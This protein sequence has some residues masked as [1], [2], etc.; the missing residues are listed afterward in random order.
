MIV[1]AAAIAAA[2]AGMPALAEVARVLEVK[3]AGVVERA[4]RPARILGAGEVLEQD[5]VVRIAPASHAILDFGERGRLT[6]RPSTVLRL[7]SPV[8]AVAKLEQG[9]VR[10]APGSSSNATLLTPVG[11][12]SGSGAAF[13]ARLCASDCG[14]DTTGRPAGWPA[15]GP[16]LRAERVSGEVRAIGA[17]RVH[18]PLHVGG[19]VQ[20]GDEVMT[21][22]NGR[23][24][25]QVRDGGFVVLQPRTRFV[26][27]RF[28]Y[29]LRR[30]AAAVAEF[31]LLSGRIQAR[32]GAIGKARPVGYRITTALGELRTRGTVL[33]AACTDLCAAGAP[34]ASMDR[35]Q[36]PLGTNGDVVLPNGVVLETRRDANGV[37]R[38]FEKLPSRGEP[39][40]VAADGTPLYANGLP[41]TDGSIEWRFEVQ[42]S[43]QAVFTD[44]RKAS[45]AGRIANIV[46]GESVPVGAVVV[47]DGMLTFLDA[48]PY[49]ANETE[50]IVGSS[51]GPAGEQ[52]RIEQRTTRTVD[53]DG[54]VRETPASGITGNLQLADGARLVSGDGPQIGNIVDSFLEARDRLLAPGPTPPAVVPVEPAEAPA[55]KPGEI[56]LPNGVVLETRL[57]PDGNVRYFEKLPPRGEPIAWLPDGTP[58]FANGLGASDGNI[59]WRFRVEPGGR[60]VFENLTGD[61]GAGSPVPVASVLARDGSLTFLAAPPFRENETAYIEQVGGRDVD[62]RGTRTI[63]LDGAISDEPGAPPLGSDIRLADG[64]RIVSDGGKI[65]GLMDGFVGARAAELRT[66]KPERPA[67]PPSPPP[68]A[69]QPPLGSSGDVV[70]PGGVV[71]EARRG[72]DGTLRFFEKQPSRGEPIG[73]LPDGSPL[74]ADGL[75]PTDG[76]LEWKFFVYENGQAAFINIAE[77]DSSKANTSGSDV[78]E[79]L[80]G[81][82][83]VTDGALT[84]LEVPPYRQAETGDHHTVRHT[85]VPSQVDG[86][87]TRSINAN[88]VVIDDPA[89]VPLPADTPLAGGGRLV[90]GGGAALQDV[91]SAYLAARDGFLP[92]GASPT[93]P[94]ASLPGSSGGLTVSTQQGSVDVISPGG[95]TSV[96]AGQTVALT[97]DSPANPAGVVKKSSR[98]GTD[99]AT[100]PSEPLPDAV[101]GTVPASPGQAVAGL[102]VWVR[103]GTVNVESAGQTTQVLAG[104]GA[105]AARDSVS[106]LQNQPD[107][108]KQD[109]TPRPDQSEEKA[110]AAAF[111]A[112]DGSVFGSCKVR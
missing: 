2:T 102:H 101:P 75:A 1:A 104:A 29:D 41:R 87:K 64:G 14:S 81:A 17:N 94:A 31:A 57:G 65:G 99:L 105:V 60:A 4:G 85:G 54:T 22:G 16:P 78:A 72:A 100:A 59:E 77:S 25:L 39:I 80:V 37:V 52:G 95:A 97:A 109:G 53:P 55:L 27:R 73:V 93:P 11:R 110:V 12:V 42:S 43:G 13:D 38:F 7:E 28:A 74:Y 108:M 112:P 83:I 36:P 48:P 19:F 46:P 82:A 68:S 5:D 67:V 23:A 111:L 96:D 62:V 26:V 51:S 47:R 21:L 103:Q 34:A 9:G 90:G 35:R 32:T 61:G 20:E 15:V 98:W 24:V 33:D 107:F 89:V 10:Y 86:R 79:I 30:P 63:G 40:G 76:N 88:G 69:A 56:R 84:F 8:S 92:G 71:L 3:G 44:M 18:R 66:Q 58:L 6:L 91:V 49:R 106:L 50:A 45:G 70:L